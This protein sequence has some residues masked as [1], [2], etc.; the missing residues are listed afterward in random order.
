MY[1]KW[2]CSI[3][4]YRMYNGEKTV[5]S[6]DGSGKTDQIHVKNKI[7]SFFNIIHTKKCNIN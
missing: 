3:E 2:S 6:T 4:E 7:R 5:S 1:S